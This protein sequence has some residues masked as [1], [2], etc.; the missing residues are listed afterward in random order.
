MTLAIAPA[1]RTIVRIIVERTPV[2]KMEEAFGFIRECIG[3]KNFQIFL[4]QMT[5]T[6]IVVEDLS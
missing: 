2:D 1:Q 5:L 6:D 4:N 3:E